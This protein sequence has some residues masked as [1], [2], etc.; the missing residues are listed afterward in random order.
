M[1]NCEGANTMCSNYNILQDYE[2]AGLTM[3]PPPPL[4]LSMVSASIWYKCEVFPQKKMSLKESLNT[5]FRL[6]D[7][8]HVCLAHSL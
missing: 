4:E 6:G 3:H 7:P 5:L 1:P 2:T 8:K